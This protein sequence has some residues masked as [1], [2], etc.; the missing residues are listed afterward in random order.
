MKN[1]LVWTILTLCLI[2]TYAYAASTGNSSL[3]F[4]VVAG[5]DLLTKVEDGKSLME[6]ARR[7]G[8]GYENVLNSNPGIDPW[9]PETKSE[10]LLPGKAILPYGTKLGLRINLAELRLFHIYKTQEGHYQ[11][12]IYPLGIGREGRETPEGEYHIIVKQKNP[13]W[14]V[15]KGLRERDPTLPSLVPPGPENPLG[16]FWLGLSASG[17]GVHGT[18]RPLGVGR[19]V[20]YGCLRMYPEDIAVL[21]DRVR[22]GLSVQISYQPIKAARHGNELLLEVHPDYLQKYNDLFQQALT[23]ISKTSWPGDI[24]YNKVKTIISEQRGRPVRIG[25][26]I[27]K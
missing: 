23:V 13:V 17:Y 24:D 9:Q 5:E 22:T 3:R 26:L 4:P 14:R 15:P 2:S 18:N 8:Y 1:A 27:D 25:V 6:V 10:V 12:D 21:Y 7:E 20:S 19:R 16:D 11:T